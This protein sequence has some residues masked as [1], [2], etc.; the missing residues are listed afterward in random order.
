M[1][2][3][4]LIVDDEPIARE[5]IL[6]LLEDEPDLVVVGQCGDGRSAVRAIESQMPDLVF[7][8]IQMPEM[9]GFAVLESL[10]SGP[11]ASMIPSIIFV[12]A[13]D[14][15][16]LRAFQVH[17]L[18]YLLKPVSKERMAEA[19]TYLRSHRPS[20]HH[21]Q[22]EVLNNLLSDLKA[23]RSSED[24]IVLR[25]VEE[26]LCL[27]PSEIDW[28]ESAGN[29]VCFHVGVGTYI[30]RETLSETARRLEKHNFVR[31]HRSTIVNFNRVRRLQSL[32]SGDY[33]VELRGGAKLTMSRTHRHALLGKID[34]IQTGRPSPF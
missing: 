29:Y 17:A 23:Y 27:K 32:G 13:Y 19:L 30:F 1:V 18:D 25:T 15:F 11:Q 16:A 6:S 22:A 12:T 20:V 7:L 31:I 26:V 2:R 8:D 3:R 9:D 33:A 10:G 34:R 28:V 24:R 21:E 5:R 4:V 14:R